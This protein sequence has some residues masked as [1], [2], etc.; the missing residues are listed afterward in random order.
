MPVIFLPSDDRWGNVGERFGQGLADAYKQK[1]L[2]E[3]QLKAIAALKKAQ[4]NYA[5]PSP[6]DAD[7][8]KA[9][10]QVY[11]ANGFNN[12]I[13]T[14]PRA[15]V[16]RSKA[17]WDLAN[18]ISQSQQAYKTAY[19]A[20]DQTGMDAAHNQA[21]LLRQNGK[22]DGISLIGLDSES[23]AQKAMDL[24][25]Q[26]AEIFRSYAKQKNIDVTGL[27]TNDGYNDFVKKIAGQQPVGNNITSTF[28]KELIEN[29]IRKAQADYAEAQK[30]NDQVGMKQ[31]HEW[32]EFLRSRAGNQGIDLN[33]GTGI[34]AEALRDFNSNFQNN[35]QTVLG[36]LAKGENF[37]LE[38]VQNINPISFEDI[39][40]MS[41]GAASAKI[42]EL[43]Q[44]I[45][46]DRVQSNFNPT[47]FMTDI[48][49]QMITENISPEV[50][51]KVL[52]LGQA[53]AN[54][55]A[56]GRKQAQNLAFAKGFSKAVTSKDYHSA[57]AIAG[58]Y[59]LMN[60]CKPEDI[61]KLV[62]Q[63][64]PEY[65]TKTIDNGGY[66][67]IGIVDKHGGPSNFFNTPK[68]IDL[69]RAYEANLGF[70]GKVASADIK[71]RWTYKKDVD[72]TALNNQG[73][74][75]VQGMK[76]NQETGKK[77][78]AEQMGKA[79]K[80]YN[81]IM[82]D[83]W[84]SKTAPERAAKIEHYMQTLNSLGEMLD[85]NVENDIDYITKTNPKGA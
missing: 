3:E 6:M 73:K 13:G 81:E 39:D 70:K 12:I 10:E 36:P 40:K 22:R 79:N 48:Y 50:I 35:G 60:N 19:E 43:A 49:K 54:D 14:D 1:I 18:G 5:K 63:I 7:L 32:A 2:N 85:V 15:G 20:G 61:I 75:V 74:I 9:R 52:P 25:H 24:A 38:P 53:Y 58:E 44:G 23:D 84:D 51:A 45:A 64:A 28:S 67:T 29:G 41:N 71:G 77:P 80:T 68:T 4:E 46:K 26:R 37:T 27:G 47:D 11:S 69:T 8:Q 82:A 21:E 17:E 31:A 59:A 56:T 33:E 83:I 34:G 65:D 57:S 62:G 16:S 55:V 30:N 78:S 66:N 76:R 72:S 42:D